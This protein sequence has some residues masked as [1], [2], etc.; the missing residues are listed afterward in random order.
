M[1][2]AADNFLTPKR[3]VIRDTLRAMVVSG[4]ITG[5]LDLDAAVLEN[6]CFELLTPNRRAVDVFE[7][8]KREH[9]DA[10]NDS[11]FYNFAKAF[12]EAYIR[13]LDGSDLLRAMKIKEVADRLDID[14]AEVRHLIDVGSLR[15]IYAVP[16]KPRVP[17]ASLAAFLAASNEEH[18]NSNTGRKD[19]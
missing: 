18:C 3:D 5:M 2:S 6:L 11:A 7:Q 16:K 10:I 9:T 17:L 13:R 1:S 15:V 8:M 14:P 12:R 4:R 19:T